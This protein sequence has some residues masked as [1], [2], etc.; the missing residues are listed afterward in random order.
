MLR[1]IISSGYVLYKTD[2]NYVR[3]FFAATPLL[4]KI[5]MSDKASDIMG[6]FFR[7]IFELV[8]KLVFIGLFMYLPRALAIKFLDAGI[9][10]FGIED[11]FVYLTVILVCFSGSINNSAL[12][13]QR[14]AD[15]VSI[16]NMK[17]KS[18]YYVRFVV[19]RRSIMELLSF[20]AA[21]SI[22]GMN[23]AKS[24]YLAIV[25]VV[26]RFAG[27]T[28]RIHMFRMFKKALP[29]LHVLI[30]IVALFFAYFFPYIRGYVPAAYKLIFD[31]VWIAIIM[32]VGALFIYYVWIF[33][34]YDKIAEYLLRK[35]EMLGNDEPEDDNAEPDVDTTEDGMRALIEQEVDKLQV[36]YGKINGA[37]YKNNRTKIRN[38]IV[39]RVAIVLCILMVVVISGITGH[40]DFIY[41]VITFALPAMFFVV[42][43]LNVSGKILMQMY[44][45]V[46][47]VLLSH[48]KCR[49][50]N[51]ILTNFF[52][53]LPKLILLDLIAPLVLVAVTIIAGIIAGHE[54]S[55]SL[56]LYVCLGILLLSIMYTVIN[57]VI[58]YLIQPYKT[59]NATLVYNII[60]IAL[61]L[62]GALLIYINITPLTFVLIAGGVLGIMVAGMMMSVQFLSERTYRNK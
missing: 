39:I 1:K 26:S 53:R 15:Y 35:Y 9:N 19:L 28:V 54:G 37:F 20:F 43:G 17:I 3:R 24:L 11:V 45:Q 29:G 50:K 13:A 36:D 51:E 41:K 21:F 5:K 59:K 2:A 8:K 55:F 58:T 31:N 25:I 49:R 52:V 57:L 4:N 10:G 46:D 16:R 33:A 7:L 47:N 61:Y 34:G 62:V 56:V 60:N 22:W 38:D 48:I 40:E 42:H 44:C 14:E 18:R 6:A 32:L 30:M 23:P 12:F 27:D